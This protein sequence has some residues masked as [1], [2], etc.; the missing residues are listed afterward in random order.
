MPNKN[1]L[2]YIVAR[3]VED[4]AHVRIPGIDKSFDKMTIGDLVQ[5]RPG[6]DAQDSYDIK[7][8]DTNLAVSTSNLLME[9]GRTAAA[10]AIQREVVAGKLRGA[11]SLHSV[12]TKIQR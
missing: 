4:I 10:K 2:H 8:V 6:G 7:G 3:N 1:Q 5:M 11:D 12:V 9:L